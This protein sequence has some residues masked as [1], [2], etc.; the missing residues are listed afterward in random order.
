MPTPSS[1]QISMG[2]VSTETTAVATM[3]SFF[4]ISNVAGGGGL[5]Y[6]NLLMGPGNNL[7]AKQAIYDVY[8][9]GTNFE[10]SAWYNYNHDPN[11]LLDFNFTNNNPDYDIG[12][13][14]YVSDGINDYLVLGT[15]LPP[16]SPPYQAQDFD[17]MV[18]TSTVGLQGYYLKIDANANYLGPPPPPGPGVNGNTTSASDVDAVGAGTTRTT[19]NPGN[20]DEF[21]PLAIQIVAA[22]VNLA[23]EI[24]INKRTLLELVFN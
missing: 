22:G 7:T 15:N 9:A 3:E 8:T 24:P 23:T 19:V 1:G 4:Q 12:I 17:T 21:N 6:H 2:D 5:M 11:I 16:G 18:S 13:Q 14:V 20:F 10:L